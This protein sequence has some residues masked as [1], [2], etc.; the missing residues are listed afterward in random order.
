MLGEAIARVVRWLGRGRP[1]AAWRLLDPDDDRAVPPHCDGW[2]LHEPGFCDFCDLHP[3][4]QQYRKVARIKFT[5][6]PSFDRYGE[7]APCPSESRR[8]LE[9]IER[10]PGNRPSK[11]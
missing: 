10:W 5:G 8:P 7:L 1:P 9:T 4:W 2:V 3:E 11:L 6:G